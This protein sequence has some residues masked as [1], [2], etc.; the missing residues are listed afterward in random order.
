[1]VQRGVGISRVWE[2]RQP[3]ERESTGGEWWGNRGSYSLKEG[4]N[5]W[6]EGQEKGPHTMGGLKEVP[7]KRGPK[8]EGECRVEKVDHLPP[9][10]LQ[11]DELNKMG[12]KKTWGPPGKG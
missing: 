12:W 4:R 7:T 6:R 8:A 9:Q 11:N 2:A 10:K 3:V 5:C 1:V